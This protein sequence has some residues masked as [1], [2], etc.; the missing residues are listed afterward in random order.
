MSSG[1]RIPLPGGSRI[2]QPASSRRRQSVSA[3][4]RD[5]LGCGP[6]RRE[7]SS[8]ALAN[9]SNAASTGA[10]AV[11]GPPKAT[12]RAPRPSSLTT[13]PAY[14]P[15]A[16]VRAKAEKLEQQKKAREDRM[17]AKR[18]AEAAEAEAR[19]QKAEAL[20][21]AKQDRL[22]G[23]RPGGR[24][25]K[26]ARRSSIGVR[27]RAPTAAAA[28]ASPAAASPAAASVK[29]PAVCSSPV[30][31]KPR[32]DPNE[33]ARKKQEAMAQA[34][35]LREERMAESKRRAAE[36]KAEKAREEEARLQ[37][38]QDGGNPFGTT[39]AVASVAPPVP[40]PDASASEPAPEAPQ[41][42]ESV[43]KRKDETSQQEQTERLKRQKQAQLEARMATPHCLRNSSCQCK[44]CAVFNPAPKVE[45]VETVEEAPPPVAIETV[46]PCL[47]TSS[48]TCDDCARQRSTV[49]EQAAAPPA[50]PV[51][52]EA[53]T[54]LRTS[55]CRCD[56]CAELATAMSVEDNAQVLPIRSPAPQAQQEPACQRNLSC[57][58]PEC[59]NVRDVKL[60]A[61]T[62]AKPSA[63]TQEDKAVENACKPGGFCLRSSDCQC[64]SC[65]QEKTGSPLAAQGLGAALQQAIAPPLAEAP[66]QEPQSCPDLPLELG[67]RIDAQVSRRALIYH[68]C[69]VLYCTVD[70]A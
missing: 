34:K 15:T 42:T 20:A 1:S 63:T 70:D 51:P 64:D 10:T 49:A 29:P 18:S 55:D 38:L 5:S 60:L 61:A 7:S 11:P 31:K 52:G 62:P 26:S 21:N 37:R 48:C 43:G 59:A 6:A 47:R 3:P 25:P 24:E 66:Q 40:D 27:S 44:D 46:A 4:R 12:R 8:G 41:A 22:I 9:R 50:S 65:E 57:A 28:A 58:C 68:Y 30:V 53:G 35:K 19:R 67:T 32:V 56:E 2:P 16:A 45:A 23:A 13:K 54:C 36:R 33:H 69:I 17:A 39:P 14:D